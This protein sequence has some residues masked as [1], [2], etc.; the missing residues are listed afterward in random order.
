MVTPGCTG[1]WQVSGRNS[2]GFAEMVKLDIYY[3]ENRNLIFDLK[4]ICRTFVVVI[5]PNDAS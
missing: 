2:I 5:K 1:L 3:I 4:I